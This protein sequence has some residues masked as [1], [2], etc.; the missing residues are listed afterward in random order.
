VRL[1]IE[2]DLGTSRLV[3]NA[4]GRSESR[5][6]LKVRQ[7]RLMQL[8]VGYR[9]AADLLSEDGVESRGP[10]LGVLEALFSGPTPYVAKTDEF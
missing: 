8:V 1:R 6:S 10:A 3:L 2:T 4:G 9:P 5:V 7:D